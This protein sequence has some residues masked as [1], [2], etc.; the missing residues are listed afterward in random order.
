MYNHFIKNLDWHFLSTNLAFY[1]RNLKKIK[2]TVYSNV[3]GA[4]LYF[5]SPSLTLI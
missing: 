4:D 1:D 3:T 5:F 2:K